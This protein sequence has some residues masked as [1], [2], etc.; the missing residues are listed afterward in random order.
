MLETAAS[1]RPAVIAIS[2]GLR[3][4]DCYPDTGDAATAQHNATDVARIMSRARGTSVLWCLCLLLA[5]CQGVISPIGSGTTRDGLVCRNPSQFELGQA[6]VRRLTNTEYLNTVRDLFGPA[7][8]AL[9]EQPSDA[10][11]EGSFENDASSLGPS[12]VRTARYEASAFILGEHAVQDSA[13]KARVLPCVTQDASC[14]QA[15]VEQFGRRVFRR[16]LESDELSR[17]SGYFEARRAEI[18]F[19]AAVQLTVTALLQA[20]QF[21]YRLELDGSSV[22][23]A[24]LELTQFELANRLSFLLWESMPD[25]ELLDLAAAGGLASDGELEAQARRM[26]T[27]D[28]AREAVRNFGRQWLHLDRVLDQDKL[29]DEFPMWSDSVK[30]SIYEESAAFFEST[31]L[32]GGTLSDLLTS[33]VAYLDDA[34]AALYQVAPPAEPWSQTTLDSSERAGILSRLAFLAGNA[35]EANGS[36]PLRGI[37]VMERLLCEDR[38]SPPADADLSVPVAE[39]GA[40]PFTNRDLF[41]E[42]TSP[43]SCQGCHVRIDGFGFGFENYDAAGIFRELDNGL[44]VDATGFANGIGNDAPYSGA[45]ELQNLLAESDTVQD[46]VAEQ[47]LTYALGR[48]LQAEDA[49]YLEGISQ[50]FAQSGGTL[51]DLMMSIVLRPEFRLRPEVGE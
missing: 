31:V 7:I 25:D 21:L 2:F 11:L 6:P 38:P 27:D 37:F 46:C 35:H 40:G 49:C 33:N 17:W 28:R 39:E 41:E 5:G 15:F 4:F 1:L 42:R 12:D 45:L 43:S 48:D 18:D 36:P 26:L 47:W 34:T 22:G 9:P 44:P 32:E 3:I 30:E 14:G 29:E 20:P 50:S 13:A 16:P 10:A 24:R 19:D 51:E 23:G 8:P